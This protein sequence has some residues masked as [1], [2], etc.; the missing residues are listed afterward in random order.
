M[1]K[2]T[3]KRHPRGPRS[4]AQWGKF[5]ALAARGQLKGGKAKARQIARRAR[6]HPT[7]YRSLPRYVRG[8]GRHVR[9]TTRSR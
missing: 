7:K 8:G 4:K 2:G 3:R 6:P 5:F 1:P 9:R